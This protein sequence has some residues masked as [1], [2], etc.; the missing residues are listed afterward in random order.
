MSCPL[1]VTELLDRAAAD[2]CHGLR[3]LDRKEDAAWFSW[4][5]I[6][7]RALKTAANLHESGV[8][9][10]DHVALIYPSCIEFFDAFFGTLYAGA[11]PA[12]LYP[13]VRLGRLDEYH[14]R[15]AA[16]IRAAEAKLVL[17]DP[18]VRRVIGPTIEL[19]KPELGCRTLNHLK[20]GAL[21]PNNPDAN[22]LALIQ[23][24]SGTTVEPKP[25][26]LSHR[27]LL[28]QAIILNSFWPEIDDIED[29]GVSWLPLYHDMGLIGCIMPALERPGTLTLIPPELFVTRPALWL[30]A[31]STYRATVSPAPNFAYG[32][33]VAKIRDEELEGVDLSS[34]RVALNGAEAVAPEVLRAFQQRFARWGF[35]VKALTPVY[36]LSEAALAVS[37]SNLDSN[38]TSTFFDRDDLQLYGRA[39]QDPTGREIVSVGRALPGFEL[40]IV[41]NDNKPIADKNVGRILVSGP[42]LMEGYYNRADATRA[43]FHDG[44][45]DTGDLGF[46]FEGELYLTGRAKDVLILRGRNFAPEEVEYPLSRIDG[47]RNGCAVAISYLP[48]GGVGEHLIVFAETRHGISS[49]NALAEECRS[50]ILGDSGLQPDRIV[51]LEAGTMPR[52]SSGKLRR[53]ETLRRFL[54]DELEPPDKVNALRIGTAMLRSAMADARV[55]RKQ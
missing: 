52:T 37:F 21:T 23:F 12:P 14:K 26:A 42:S 7:E 34:W 3:L 36:G 1:T 31:I 32:L 19:S 39:T 40:R 54:T 35:Q 33:A 50:A 30:R 15:T 47:I 25:V 55:K 5:I 46:F 24:S 44:W 13:P 45:L 20:K 9:P 8:N 41:D 27:A 28:A 29:S 10:G 38:F 17:V 6:R 22:S 51:L 43:V 11:V 4:S 49:S 53:Q 48:E 18:W 16:M 2:N